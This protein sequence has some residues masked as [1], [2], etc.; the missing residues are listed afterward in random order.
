MELNYKDYGLGMGYRT[1]VP[2]FCPKE[3]QLKLRDPP[4][5]AIKT[6]IWA[7]RKVFKL[8]A[9]CKNLALVKE[10]QEELSSV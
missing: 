8:K 2:R 4:N 5:P 3:F 9:D 7:W 6:S 10:E 1:N